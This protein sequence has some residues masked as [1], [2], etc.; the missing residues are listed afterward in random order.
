MPEADNDRM[1]EV[2]DA[3]GKRAQVAVVMACSD[4][5]DRGVGGIP[6]QDRGRAVSRT[7]SANEVWKGS[8]QPL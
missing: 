2:A 4:R 3:I 1:A 7:V 6:L 8:P 5:R